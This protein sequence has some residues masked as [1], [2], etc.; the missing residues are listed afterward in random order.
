MRDIQ[1]KRLPEIDP[2]E[3]IALMN[4]PDIRRHLPL[5][6]GDFGPEECERFVEAKEKMW[7]EHGFG[8]WAF[9]QNGEFIGWGGLQPEGD[10]A[11]V[12]LILRP[13][14]WGIGRQ[15]YE[16]TVAFAF[17]ELELDSVI[18][19]LP[20]TRTRGGGLQRLG[21]EPD[22]ETVIAGERFVRFRLHRS[23]LRQTG[24]TKSV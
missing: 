21:F 5:A 10:D 12:G 3:I 8:P 24:P 16:L 23:R 13:Q 19:M 17:Q 22:G 9:V 11:D 6:S 1:L 4:D 2:D 20:P 14:S 7:E 15:L 18:A